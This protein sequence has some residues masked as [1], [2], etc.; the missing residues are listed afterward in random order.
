[1][2]FKFD[3][4]EPFP[5]AIPRI[6]Q[7]RIN[8]IIESLSE[9]PH[10]GAEAIHDARKNLKSLRALLRLTR[11][12]IDG[13]LRTRENTKF[14]DAGRSLSSLRDPQALL[15]ALEY[16]SKRHHHSAESLTP[17]RASIRSFIDK[18]RTEIEQSLVAGLPPEQ[19]KKLLKE[20]REARRR[21][22]LW[23]EGTLIQPGSEWETFVGN[24]LRK[25]YRKAKNLVWQ[26]EVIGPES[27]DDTAWHE[28]RKCAKALGY[29][30]RLL[31][32]IWP[33][34]LNAFVDELDQLTDRLGDANDLSI[35]R[36]RIL[37]QPYDPAETPSAGETRRFFL[38]SIDRR[39]QKLHSEAFDLARLIYMEKSGQFARRLGGYW[40]L[41]LLQNELKKTRSS[42]QKG[43]RT[44]PRKNREQKANSEVLATPHSASAA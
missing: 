23:F 10:P 8:Q 25:T 44:S 14:R 22:S 36:G 5:K 1:M 39:K 38:Q 27:A 33:G 11:G 13:G 43:R 42:S 4:Q 31:K 2:A 7:E 32:P 34:M 30:L 28:L 12:A 6:A 17:K 26:F 40:Q 21:A 37:K 18:M 19:I 35:L 9:K 41:L 29:Q 16:F 24:G 15:E 20:L 3:T